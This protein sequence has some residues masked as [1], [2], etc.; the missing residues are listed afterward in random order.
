MQQECASL[1]NCYA[2][3]MHMKPQPACRVLQFIQ[4][5]AMCGSGVAKP[6]VCGDANLWL[7]FQGVVA[8]AAPILPS[9]NCCKSHVYTEVCTAIAQPQ[10]HTKHRGVRLSS[11]Q[12]C[13]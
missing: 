3:L 6:A 10:K 5:R 13:R 8:T 11:L 9:S 7:C 4:L 1:A 12:M 2:P